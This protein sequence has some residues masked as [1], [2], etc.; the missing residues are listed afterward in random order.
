MTSRGAARSVS[1]ILLAC[2]TCVA[3][4]TEG[5]G[6]APPLPGQPV[7]SGE[8]NPIGDDGAVVGDDG[9]T[10]EGGAASPDPA[11][12]CNDLLHGLKAFFVLP[13]VPCTSGATCPSGDCC[14]VGP[15]SSTCVMQ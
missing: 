9:G 14:Y 1:A 8:S 3:C 5:P 11:G 15:S 10:T 2:A 7:L 13:P 12:T 4:A 6:S